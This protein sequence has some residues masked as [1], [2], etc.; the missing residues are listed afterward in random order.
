MLRD[1]K[2]EMWRIVYEQN[3]WRRPPPHGFEHGLHSSQALHSSTL[4]VHVYFWHVS[5]S[6][7]NPLH[8]LFGLFGQAT[9][10]HW[11]SSVMNSFND[12]TCILF[13]ELSGQV[14]KKQSIRSK[15]PN[16]AKFLALKN[17]KWGSIF[18]FLG[19]LRNRCCWTWKTIKKRL[20]ESQMLQQTLCRISASS[21]DHHHSLPNMNSKCSMKTRRGNCWGYIFVLR[22]LYLDIHS[23]RMVRKLFAF[24]ECRQSRKQYIKTKSS[25]GIANLLGNP[26]NT[27]AFYLT[28]ILKSFL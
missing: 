13:F 7:A 1:F 11:Y 20:L 18:Y 28:A 26:S 15:M 27:T 4:T 10:F 3:L 16:F 21:A 12:S 17:M 9:K 25:I 24:V 8:W 19:H 6:S 14:R 22:S 23:R 5:W 2:Q